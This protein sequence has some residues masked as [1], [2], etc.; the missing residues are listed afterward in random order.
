[1]QAHA[2]YGARSRHRERAART[3]TAEGA[4][5]LEGWGEWTNSTPPSIGTPPAVIPA[6]AEV[7]PA[8][9]EVTPAF[10]GG[11]RPLRRAVTRPS[12]RARIDPFSATQALRPSGKPP[13][14]ATAA[15]RK[16]D[17]L[18]VS[19]GFRHP[20]IHRVGMSMPEVPTFLS[21]LR[22]QTKLL[23]I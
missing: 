21:L 7:P 17:V 5:G 8:F 18:G 10:S 15:R 3:Y 22:R 12:P 9:L 4:T 11:A 13:S 14:D 2:G 1:V 19:P 16:P 23:H 20:R 6:R